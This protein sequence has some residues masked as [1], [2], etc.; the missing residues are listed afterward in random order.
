LEDW[1]WNATLSGAPQ[2]GVVSPVLS[3]IYLD[4]LDNFVETVLIP[5]YTRGSRRVANPAG[6]KMDNAMAAAR[7]R[8]DRASS[9][10]GGALQRRPPLR[11]VLAG[12]LAHGSSKPL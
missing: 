3:N 8:G 10:K 6:R 5:E 12:F 11:T 9:G 7:E 2:G 4:R 1:I